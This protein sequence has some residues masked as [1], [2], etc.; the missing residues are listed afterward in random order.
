[1][2]QPGMEILFDGIQSGGIFCFGIIRQLLMWCQ[3][4]FVNIQN[5]NKL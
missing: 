5:S 3:E 1:M 2:T 4:T